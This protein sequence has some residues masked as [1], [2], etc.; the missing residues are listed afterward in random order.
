MITTAELRRLHSTDKFFTAQIENTPSCRDM[1]PSS[2]NSNR[3][4]HVK[5]TLLSPSPAALQAKLNAAAPATAAAVRAVVPLPKPPRI[6]QTV[7]ITCPSNDCRWNVQRFCSYRFNGVLNHRY[8]SLFPC[9]HSAVK[10]P[11]LRGSRD[12]EHKQTAPYNSTA[13]PLCFVPCSFFCSKIQQ[14]NQ[15]NMPQL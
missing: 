8:S 6:L 4:R 7:S 11:C 10:A 12:T 14:I 15:I 1:Q 13:T 9:D 2:T 5:N 3:P